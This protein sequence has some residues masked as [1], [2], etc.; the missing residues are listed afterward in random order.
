[1]KDRQK[2]RDDAKYEY[3]RDKQ[4]VDEIVHK[5]ALEDMEAD[6][7]N[8]QKK[9]QAK[10][11]MEQAYLEKA[12]N[13]RRRKME[14]WIQREKERQYFESVV[15]REGELKAKKAA[16]QLEKDKIFERLSEEKKRQ[17]AEKE[18]WENVRNELYIEDM[19]RKNK[20]KE[21]E[22]LE[23]KQRQKEEMLASAIEQAEYKEERRRQEKLEEAEFKRKLIEQYKQD[24]KLE[25][26]NLVKRKQKE[27]DFK[28]EIEKQWREKLLQYQIQKDHE[29]NVLKQQKEEEAKNRALIEQEKLRL[30]KENEDI[31]KTYMGKEFLKQTGQ[32]IM[33]GFNGR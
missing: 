16:V 23:K 5:I 24:E 20:I 21:L 2:Q 25:Q 4:H 30:L 7:I 28:E 13:E 9:A 31:L 22:E 29:L 14:D 12:D 33:N 18:Y 10:Q 6:R 17:Q 32:N 15:K 3:D 11:F 27:M 1:M 26:Y 8:R 19:N